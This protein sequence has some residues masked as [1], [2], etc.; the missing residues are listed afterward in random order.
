MKGRFVK[1]KLCPQIVNGGR[2]HHH[3][4]CS[5]A[6]GSHEIRDRPH[7]IKTKLCPEVVNGRACTRPICNY[8]HVEEELNTAP[9]ERLENYKT[10]LCYFHTKQKSGDG[11]ACK[12]GSSCRFAHGEGEL[13]RSRD[14]L[15]GSLWDR[16]DRSDSTD[17]ATRRTGD[18]SSSPCMSFTSHDRLSLVDA[19]LGN[20]EEPSF[21]G[22]QH[23][24]EPSF[25]GC[26][27]FEEP[28]SRPIFT[29]SSRPIFT[30]SSRPIFADS[31]IRVCEP[32]N[33]R[34]NR[35]RYYA[36]DFDNRIEN[37]VGVIEPSSGFTRC[38]RNGFSRLSAV[39]QADSFGSMDI[40]GELELL[41]MKLAHRILAGASFSSPLEVPLFPHQS[42]GMF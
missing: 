31:V 28:S 38:S 23:F 3:S 33:K 18:D 35:V 11:P 42:S 7:L 32:P 34:Q 37:R 30:D 21:I 20:F 41:R 12:Y 25:I 24:E 9:T 22:C 13:R 29:D 1:T 15:K 5:Y 39:K 19:I 6:H 40:A 27:H 36:S 17:T 14:G 10:I 8:A 4:K 26:Q 16:A 2:C